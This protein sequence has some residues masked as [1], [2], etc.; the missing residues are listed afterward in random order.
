[1]GLRPLPTMLTVA[2]LA[3]LAGWSIRTARRYL[4]AWF[5]MQTNPRVPRVI[6]TRTGKR[7]RPPYVVDRESYMQWSLSAA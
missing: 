6:V 7:G 4:S 2:K 3:A 1:M 5:A